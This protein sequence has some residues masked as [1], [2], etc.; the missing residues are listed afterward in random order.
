MNILSLNLLNYI[1]GLSSRTPP[2]STLADYYSAKYH[3]K[4]F[5]MTSTF[6]NPISSSSKMTI[7]YVKGMSSRLYACVVGV[8]R[9][10]HSPEFGIFL[11]FV[12]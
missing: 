5:D 12:H 7:S 1:T 8:P 10:E 4:M 9:C 11:T 6:A 3:Y 2:N